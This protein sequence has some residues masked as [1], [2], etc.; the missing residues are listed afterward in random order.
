MSG[1]TNCIKFWDI[2]K[3]NIPVKIIEDHHTLLLQTMYNHAHD[4]L[5]LECYDDGA[6]GLFRMTSVSSS[7][8]GDS[9]ND[10]LVRLYDDHEDSVYCAAWSYSTPWFFGSVP[11]N[12]NNFV[13]NVVPDAE[14]FRILL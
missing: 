10:V 6:I 5:L 14:K 9:A 1:H 2:R 12:A 4:E 8:N 3:T 7:P 11:Y 13:V